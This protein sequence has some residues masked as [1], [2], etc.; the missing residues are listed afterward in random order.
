LHCI[1]MREATHLEEM[2]IDTRRGFDSTK[3]VCKTHSRFSV[4]SFHATFS[5]VVVWA[6]SAPFV[7]TALMN[8]NIPASELVRAGMVCISG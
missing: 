1:T 8:D 2:L 3:P 5:G 6:F 7:P 4:S